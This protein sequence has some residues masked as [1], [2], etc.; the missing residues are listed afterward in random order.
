MNENVVKNFPSEQHLEA[1]L[2]DKGLSEKDYRRLEVKIKY[3]NAFAN[4]RKS[5]AA[6]MSA[7]A[8]LKLALQGQERLELERERLEFDK[9]VFH[10]GEF[11]K[12][13]ELAEHI[14]HMKE[15]DLKRVGKIMVG[16]CSEQDKRVVELMKAFKQLY[17]VDEE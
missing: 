1:V 14:D 17:S 9:E 3:M 10:S 11:A 4:L 8:Q 6:V 2:N 5:E 16:L 7:D 13:L 12:N 15:K